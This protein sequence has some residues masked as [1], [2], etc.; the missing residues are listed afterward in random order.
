MEISGKVAIITGAGGGGSGRAIAQRLVR[1]GASV[2]V[3]DID[4][5]GGR[6][7]LR[8]IEAAQG[9]VVFVRADVSIQADVRALIATAEKTFGG[10]DILVN[11]AGPYYLEPLGHWLETVQANL[12][13]TMYGTLHGIEAMRRRGGGA[14]VN[15]GSTSSL[16]HGRKHSPAP[17][18]DAAKAGVIRLTTGLGWL[19]ERENIRVNCLV[20]DWVATEEVK[21]YWDTLTPQQ[22][23][24]QGVP[25]VLTPVEEIADAVVELITDETLAGRVMILWSG[26]PRRVIPVGDPGYA[27]LE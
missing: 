21:A 9:R 17:A 2:V 18:Y 3:S 27:A 24:E 14:I 25:D 7:T 11:N 16:G 22:R 13:G 15:I 5:R 6:E 8:R 1:E 26:Q 12:L 20:P 4:E 10:A 23:K 19:R